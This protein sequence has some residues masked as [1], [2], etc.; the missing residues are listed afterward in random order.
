MKLP[1]FGAVPPLP[2]CAVAHFA[3]REIRAAHEH[4]EKSHKCAGRWS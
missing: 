2:F 3:R 4:L 1:H